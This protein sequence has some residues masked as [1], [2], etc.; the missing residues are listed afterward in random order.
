MEEKLEVQQKTR[1]SLDV[2]AQRREKLRGQ[3]KQLKQLKLRGVEPK[4]RMELFRKINVEFKLYIQM[5]Q[6]R[7]N[8]PE[9]L[10]KGRKNSA[11]FSQGFVT[12]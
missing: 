9:Q 2:R 5:C 3:I 6:Q 7:Q 1:R 8:A 4:H 12:T 11:G 10:P